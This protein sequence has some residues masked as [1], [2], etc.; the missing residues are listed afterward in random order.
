M[1]FERSQFALAQNPLPAAGLED[2]MRIFLFQC[3]ATGLKVQGFAAEAVE[4]GD[5][6]TYELVGCLA[7][8]QAHLVDPNTGKTVGV[9]ED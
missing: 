3:P 1:F 6:E 7:C 4:H 8:G 5:R 9:N 2:R